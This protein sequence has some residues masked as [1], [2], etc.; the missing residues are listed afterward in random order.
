M[1]LRKRTVSP[2]LVVDIKGLPGLIG[3]AETDGW[4]RIGAATVLTQV[5]AQR[6]VQE[7]YPALVEAMNVVG[8]IQIRNR[9]TLGGNLVNASP[10]ADTAPPLLV[11][12]A[13]VEIASATAARVVPLADFFTGP[14]RTV[15][16]PGE[17]VTAVLVPVPTERVGSSFGRMTRR[18]G[19]DLATINLACSVSESGVTRF[20]FGAVGPRPFL[21]ADETGTLAD[22]AAPAPE[23]Q[24]ALALLTDQATPITNV[25]ASREYR[26]AMLEVLA[27]RALD[28]ARAR[29]SESVDGRA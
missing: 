17:I 19:V 4:L 20:A 6:R 8:S 3:L 29:L 28:A 24:R 11:Y 23:Q 27:R 26:Q 22:A 7:L 1:A 16:Q 13:T 21:V 9:A 14:G 10:A 5:V 12:G 2:P 18:R 15:L 25:R